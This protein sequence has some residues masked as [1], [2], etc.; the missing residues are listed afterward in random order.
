[1]AL[2]E[3]LWHHFFQKN[4]GLLH[5]TKNGLLTSYLLSEKTNEP[6]PRKRTDIQKDEKTIGQT[7]GQRR[8]DRPYFIRTFLTMSG[9]QQEKPQIKSKIK[10]SLTNFKHCKSYLLEIDMIQGVQDNADVRGL[11]CQVFSFLNLMIMNEIYKNDAN[12]LSWH[13]VNASLNKCLIKAIQVTCFG[14]SNSPVV[15]ATS[16]I[17]LVENN[18]PPITYWLFVISGLQCKILCICCIFT[19]I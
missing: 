6:I 14:Y 2:S 7:D 4:L 13:T 10:H 12:T 19:D 3:H 9:G 16:N 8:Q 5:I 15:C 17:V 18:L 11:W 1:M